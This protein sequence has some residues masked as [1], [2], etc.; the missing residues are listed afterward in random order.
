MAQQLSPGRRY[1]G[2]TAEERRAERR[3]RLLDA[4][5]E[6]FGTRG[7]AAT[8]IETL[9]AAARLHPRYFYEEFDT[10]E[11]LLG[12]VYDRHIGAVTTAVGAAVEDA[13][14]EPLA[15]LKIGL[16]AF[17]DAIMADEKG[18]RVNYFEIVG[19]SPELERKRRDVLRAYAEMIAQQIRKI[20]AERPLP[21]P[22]QRLSAVA[23]VGAIDGLITD[24]LSDDQRPD[25]GRIVDTVLELVEA[26]L[27][28]WS[29][30][31]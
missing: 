25:R 21:L 8:T 30:T 10:R 6:L 1:A 5:L 12:A 24:W 29:P 18:A 11:A 16:A 23:L 9:C 15:R 7:Y 3:E 2:K 26:V 17:L 22:D 31:R 20:D 19:V 27:Q 28:R 14:L 4:G 13:P